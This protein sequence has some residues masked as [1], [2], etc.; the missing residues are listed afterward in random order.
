MKKKVVLTM[1]DP[2]GVGPRVIVKSL[3][4]IGPG[5]ADFTLVGDRGLLRRVKGFSQIESRLGIVDASNLAGSGGLSLSQAGRISLAYLNKALSILKSG[6]KYSLVT[7]PVS[8]EAIQTVYPRF[9]GHTEF[10]AEKLGAENVAMMMVGKKLRVV[11]LTR[12]VHV[13]D[14]SRVFNFL[15][16]KSTLKLTA[17]ALRDLFKIQRPTIGL[18][19]LNPHAG[20]NTYLEKEEK[21][22]IRAKDALDRRQ[23]SFIGPLPS[24]T[25][26]SKALKGGFDAVV[27]FYH[28][29]GMIP[30]KCFEFSSGVNLT[31]GLKLIR[32]SPA[33]G[34]AI[35]L[36]DRPALI[37][38]SSMKEAILMALKLAQ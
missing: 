19:S 13:R 30:F 5:K 28:D 22:L 31:L 16:A 32:T 35:D 1:G 20:I 25:L 34:P 15:E 26:F 2:R 27:A 24:D 8:K 12:H 14:I 7:G 6:K 33:H 9:S 3:L 29:Q 10:L 4:D 18:C 11:F 36:M 17:Q 21:L 37:D 23:T 38:H